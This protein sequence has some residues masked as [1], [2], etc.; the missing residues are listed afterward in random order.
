MFCVFAVLVT[1]SS[2]F[3][4]GVPQPLHDGTVVAKASGTAT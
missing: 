1:R 3:A 4:E 2:D